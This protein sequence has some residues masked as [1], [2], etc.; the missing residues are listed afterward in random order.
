MEKTASIPDV[1]PCSTCKRIAWRILY[2]A[3]VMAVTVSPAATAD[4]FFSG[5]VVNPSQAA[6]LPASAR[7]DI[8]GNQAILDVAVASPDGFALTP[9]FTASTMSGRNSGVTV[10]KSRLRNGVLVARVRVQTSG[11]ERQQLNVCLENSAARPLCGRFMI[12]HLY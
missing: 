7:I 1:S 3:L 11:H 5:R 4:L 9:V 6:F 12:N 2:A 8:A 10:M